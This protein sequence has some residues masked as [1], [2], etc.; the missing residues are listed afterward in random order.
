VELNSCPGVCVGGVLNVE[1]PFAASSKLKHLKKYLPVALSHP[2]DYTQNPEM[3]LTEKIAYEPVYMLGNS[4]LESINNMVRMEKLLRVLPGIDCG[5]CGAPT[6][7]A[8]EE[9]HIRGKGDI[10]SCTELLRRY[11][12]YGE[13]AFE[14]LEEE[15]NL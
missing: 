15:N 3:E 11:Y 8:L 7:K 12:L 10:H 13:D 14:A 4:M 5:G 1:N 2:E 9:D 6:C